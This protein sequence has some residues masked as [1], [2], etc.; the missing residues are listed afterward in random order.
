MTDLNADPESIAARLDRAIP[1]DQDAS[2][3]TD[4]HPLVRTAAQVAR[5]PK[6]AMSPEMMKRVEA[7]VLAAYDAGQPQPRRQMAGQTAFVSI[8]RW[9]AVIALVAAIFVTGGLPVVANSVPG[10]WTYAIKRGIE[11]VEWVLARTAADEAQT[12][13][14]QASRRVEEA[15]VMVERGALEPSLIVTAVEGL[16][17]ASSLVQ[18]TGDSALLPVVQAQSEVLAIEMAAILDSAS[19][20]GSVSANIADDLRLMVQSVVPPTQPAVVVAAVPATTPEMSQTTVPPA[21]ESVT[22]TPGPTVTAFATVTPTSTS[23]PSRTPPSATPFTAYVFATARVNVRSGPGMD[24]EIVAQLS[25]GQQVMI[26]DQDETGDWWQ[27]ELQ[28]R[29]IG[30]VASRLLSLQPITLRSTVR[31]N[32]PRPGADDSMGASGGRVTPAGPSDNR[33]DMPDNPDVSELPSGG[34]TEC[35]TPGASCDAPG[36]SDNPPPGQGGEPPGRIK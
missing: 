3:T 9:A 16:K 26:V 10:D 19:G 8:L 33:P 6:P 32:S 23:Q 1:P 18:Q 13:L 5:M 11:G 22:S 14:R 28:S 12:H 20:A 30:W 34:D 25:P 7:R 4:D 2:V 15:R 27:V 29:E 24:F 36:R 31:P 17:T 35:D 21:T